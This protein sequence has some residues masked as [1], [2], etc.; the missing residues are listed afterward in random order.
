M[1][2]SVALSVVATTVGPAPCCTGVPTIV[3]STTGASL[4]GATSRVT[5]VGDS[6][7]AGQTSKVAGPL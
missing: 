3:S 1:S 2:G 7:S 6:A 5:M 4:T